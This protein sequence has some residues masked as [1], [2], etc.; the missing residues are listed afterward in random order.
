MNDNFEKNYTDVIK[1]L[2]T[3]K[4]IKT[5]DNFRKRFT[6]LIIPNLP[7]FNTFKPLY[8]LPFRLA[9]IIIILILVSGTG[10][11]VAADKSHP[12]NLLYP[13]KKAVEK[14]QLTITNN[15]S[16]KTNL[17]MNNA[18]KRVDEL[19]DSIKQSGNREVENITSDYE[20][21]VKDAVRESHK[22]DNNKEDVKSMIDQKLED[23]SH[24][25]ED[26]KNVAPTESHVSIEKAIETSKTGQEEINQLQPKK[27]EEKSD[28]PNTNNR[29]DQNPLENTI[30][31]D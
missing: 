17:H 5:S 29:P 20:S 27:T 21:Q 7:T 2:R 30:H 18:D 6:T 9:F 23:Q 15:P 8:F 26:I 1:G 25:L 10:L 14:V 19:E 13:V 12:G 4:S 22:V 3:L 28:N 16:G 31:K 24:K 11:V